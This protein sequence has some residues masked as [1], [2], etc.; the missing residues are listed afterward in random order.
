M[1]LQRLFKVA[2]IFAG[3]FAS[4]ASNAQL[5]GTNVF[6]KGKYV[7]IG[8]GNAGYYGSDTAAPVGY[9]PH[10]DVCVYPNEIGFVADPLM[11]GW[12]TS[13]GSHYM[14]DYFLPGSPYEG[15]N[16]QLSTREYCE[17]NSTSGSTL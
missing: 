2:L 3:L 17:G 7:E 13:S 10:C 8:I 1:K 15:W 14:G 5:V 9:H 12:S 4:F 6:L 16:L 11:T